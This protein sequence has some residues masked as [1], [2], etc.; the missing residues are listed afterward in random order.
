MTN[1][2]SINL[3]TKQEALNK[4]LDVIKEVDRIDNKLYGKAIG[5]SVSPSIKANITKVYQYILLNEFKD[6]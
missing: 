5:I 1:P 3:I 6:K 2:P 4:L